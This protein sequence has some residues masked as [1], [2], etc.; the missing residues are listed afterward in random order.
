LAAGLITG[1]PRSAEAERVPLVCEYPRHARIAAVRFFASYTED[2]VA[3]TGLSPDTGKH[4]WRLANAW[5]NREMGKHNDS[6]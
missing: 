2:D 3:G 1:L 4:D 5:L 6:D